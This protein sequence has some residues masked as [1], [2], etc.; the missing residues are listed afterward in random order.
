M[1]DVVELKEYLKIEHEDEDVLLQNILNYAISQCET[2]L[3]RP[4]LKENMTEETA[5]EVPNQ[6]DMAVL[7]LC[8]IWYENRSPML[9]GDK[10]S[11]KQLPY[12]IEAILNPHTFRQV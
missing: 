10:Q 4:I 12:G 7:L 3:N 6:I 2:F 11:S 9:T 1:I 5:W 8:S